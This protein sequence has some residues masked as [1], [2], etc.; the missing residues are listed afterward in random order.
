MNENV[1]ILV[2]LFELGPHLWGGK[3]KNKNVVNVIITMHP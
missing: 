3:N 2:F 1:F